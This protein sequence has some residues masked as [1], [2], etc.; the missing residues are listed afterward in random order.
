MN[1]SEKHRPPNIGFIVSNYRLIL[2]MFAVLSV[3]FIWQAKKFEIDASADT[4][5]AQGNEI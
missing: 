5:L 3:G 4:L 2:L 1:N